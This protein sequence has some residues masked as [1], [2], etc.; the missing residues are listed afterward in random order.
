[1]QLLAGV[2][3]LSVE[4]YGAGPYGTMTLA[5]LGADVIKIENP[6]EGGDVSRYVPPYAEDGD[7]LF[8]Q[9]LNR[10]KRSIA[11]DLQDASDRKIFERLVAHAD[12]VFNNLR[13]DLPERLGLTYRDLAPINPRIVCCSLTGFGRTG[14]RR[15]DPGYD[16][17]VQALCGFMSMTGEPDGPPVKSAISFVDFAGG[18]TAAVGILAGLHRA[19][20]TGRGCDIDTSLYDVGL[21]ML[22]YMAIWHLSRGWQPKR[23]KRSAHSALVPVQLFTTRDGYLYI[24][25]Q[26]EK[27]WVRLCQL[28]GRT[29]LL[30]DDRF[31]TFADRLQ[32]R[33]I[34]TAEL[35]RELQQ[36]TTAEWIEILGGQVPC[37]P[38]HTLE[39]ALNDPH[40]LARGMII[41]VEH[42]RF[43]RL[44]QVG[45]PL[46]VVDEPE[47][48]PRPGPRLDADRQQI[49]QEIGYT[50]DEAP[51]ALP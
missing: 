8:F 9:S 26:K 25:C 23:Q 11:L 17:L 12:A 24:M 31:R 20:T 28:L 48:T 4:Q 18:L 49:L 21:S 35:E 42:P 10:N 46:H 30:E 47:L 6:R 15:A 22:N 5:D 50:A 33:D 16:M 14:P 36:R 27:F 37:A 45:N 34:L 3:I 13:G 7:S 44:R 41:E 39:Q 43:G 2:R 29:D 1:M 40:T 19:R 32:H 51:E 38:V